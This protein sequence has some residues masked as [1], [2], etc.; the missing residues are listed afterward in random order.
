MVECSAVYHEKTESEPN[1]WAALIEIDKQWLAPPQR[2]I[3][4][5]LSRPNG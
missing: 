4:A 1:A 3:S 2:Q 5:L